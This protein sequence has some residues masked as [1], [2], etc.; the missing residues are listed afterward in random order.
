MKSS[1]RK[2][3]YRKKYYHK[4]RKKILK[5]QRAYERLNR[6]RFLN[7]R[8]AYRRLNRKKIAARMVVYRLK[9]LEQV[10]RRDRVRYRKNHKKWA[11][12]KAAYYRKNREHVIKH[13]TEYKK[14]MVARH[15]YLL[16]RHE[17]QLV[18]RGVVGRPMSLKDHQ[19]KIYFISGRERRCWYCSGENNKL[20]SG[21]DRIDNKKTY[22]V[23]NTVPSCRGC[24]VWRG[25]AHSVQ[26]TRN[27][28]KP[29]RD[30]ARG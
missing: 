25:T 14:T 7:R 6:E 26:E 17:H 28:F 24:N 3:A 1:A 21:L 20:G 27:H 10:R 8:A 19:R 23:K 4:N 15:A 11:K 13:N 12:R 5:R 30:A 18:P 16:R 9:N 2:L 29:M 22:T